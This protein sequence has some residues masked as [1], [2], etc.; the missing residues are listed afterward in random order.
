MQ[1]IEDVLSRY[2]CETRVLLFSLA[3]IRDD[4]KMDM[5][6]SERY[7]HRFM[8]PTTPVS[9]ATC[10]HSQRFLSFKADTIN[11]H[12]SLPYTSN[13]VVPQASLT[14]KTKAPSPTTNDSILL[15]LHINSMNNAP[16]LRIT[17]GMRIDRPMLMLGLLMLVVFFIDMFHALHRHEAV[18]ISGEQGIVATTSAGAPLLRRLLS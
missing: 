8:I 6:H 9:S 11:K 10:F 4:G 16:S 7:A 1:N 5:C 3:S 14:T 18:S 13:P 15:D 12:P 17:Q 2:P